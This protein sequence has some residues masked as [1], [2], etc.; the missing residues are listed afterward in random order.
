MQSSGCGQPLCDICQ[1][2]RWLVSGGARRVSGPKLQ[3]GQC[4]VDVRFSRSCPCYSTIRLD[5]IPATY[6]RLPNGKN[7]RMADF[8]LLARCNGKARLIVIE[9]KG[10]VVRKKRTID[11]IQAALNVLHRQSSTFLLQPLPVAYLIGGREVGRLMRLSQNAPILL[12]FGSQQVQLRFGRCGNR[13]LV[14]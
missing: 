5:V 3:D 12:N 11:Q 7:S 2:E 13:I 8:G 4:S 10:N 9:M 6:R 14:R 1:L